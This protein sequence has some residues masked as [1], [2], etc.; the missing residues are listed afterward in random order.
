MRTIKTLLIGALF[1]G[2]TLSTSAWA[3]WVNGEED[4][5]E[6]HPVSS[7]EA[8]SNSPHATAD[9]VLMHA[10][11]AL[12]SGDIDG[13][14]K[15][16]RR[17]LKKETGADDIDI[18][19]TLA[20]ALEEKVKSQDERDQYLYNECVKEW[21]KVLRSEVGPEKGLTWKGLGL[22]L[23]RKYE[24]ELQGGVARAHLTELCGSAPTNKETDAKYLKRVLT[25]T[26]SSVSGKVLGGKDHENS[27]GKLSSRDGED[28]R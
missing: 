18:H 25:P 10:E 14:I 2:S 7:M 16:L 5:A 15:L 8:F 4:Y 17:A 11:Y 12:K 26:D 3:R 27:H 9:A 19:Q 6:Y 24:D 13:A 1:L 23:G 21:L 22:G 28:T 20:G